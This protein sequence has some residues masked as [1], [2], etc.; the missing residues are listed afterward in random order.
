[1]K[2][3]KRT[4]E[5]YLLILSIT[6]QSLSAIYGGINLIKDPSG[7]SLKLP[8]ALLT[9]TIFKDF[10]IPGIL[11]L[12]LIALPS[13]FLIYPL[14]AKPKWKAF[15][16]I[17]IYSNYY[18][19]YTYSI[20]NSIILISWINIQLIILDHGTL[21]HGIFGLFGTFMLILT[22]LP[23]VKSYYRNK[24]GKKLSDMVKKES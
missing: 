6:I 18:W 1:M 23:S 22:L 4:F 20:Y 8:I 12:L 9:G 5:I 11:L 19:A 24:P 16:I 21:I 15:N 14:F 17:N 2:S 3:R 10:Q 13:M 7:I